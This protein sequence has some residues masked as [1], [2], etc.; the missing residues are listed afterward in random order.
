MTSSEM[1]HEILDRIKEDG[2]I[3]FAGISKMLGDAGKGDLAIEMAHTPNAILWNGVS[4]DLVDALTVIF[5]SKLAKLVKVP[6]LIYLIEGRGLTLPIGS[7][8]RKYVGYKQP[9][10]IPVVL[11]GYTQA[12]RL[13]QMREYDKAR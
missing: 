9:H 4:Q 12:E 5:Q 10:W 13:K 2:D 1:V 8:P 3:S 7:R 6:V 11:T